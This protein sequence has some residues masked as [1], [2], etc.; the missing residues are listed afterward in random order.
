MKFKVSWMFSR[1]C[2]SIFY[3]YFDIYPVYIQ[4]QSVQYNVE[5]KDIQNHNDITKAVLWYIAI[6]QPVL[7][8]VLLYM[9][10]IKTRNKTNV[11]VYH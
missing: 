7:Q 6:Y 8:Y 4:A 3:Q 9:D 10:T 5:C 2:T 1:I 11:T